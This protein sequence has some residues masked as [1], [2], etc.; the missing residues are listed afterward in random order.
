M[1]STL[2]FELLWWCS[3]C[4]S[5]HHHQ[6]RFSRLNGEHLENRFRLSL[7]GSLRKV[8]NIID[9]DGFSLYFLWQNDKPHWLP[10]IFSAFFT[11][12]SLNCSLSRS[13][14]E[15]VPHWLFLLI[16]SHTRLTHICSD[17]CNNFTLVFKCTT[18]SSD[19]VFFFCS[20]TYKRRPFKPHAMN[21][22][23]VVDVWWDISS[24]FHSQ[25]VQ[26]S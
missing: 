10:L 15:K 17:K 9:R 25:F 24:T 2:P 6:K 23:V 1:M 19:K 22:L 21:M 7:S 4:V 12:F 20:V 5:A 13:T 18:S 3:F 16:F 14:S 8:E 26:T 11:P